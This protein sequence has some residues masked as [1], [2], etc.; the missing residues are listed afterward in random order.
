M[1]ASA[2]QDTY[3]KYAVAA[4]MLCLVVLV[5]L[6]QRQSF[7]WDTIQ[8]SSMQANFFYEHGF[9]QMLLPPEIDSGHPPGFGL[10]LAFCWTL[11]GKSLALSH[12]V[13]LP[14]LL[15][16]VY[17]L[18]RLGQYFFAGWWVLVAPLLALLDPVLLGQSVLVSPDIALVFFFL[19]TTVGLFEKRNV[20]LLL[21]GLGLVAISMRGMMVLAAL[22]VFQLAKSWLE[23]NKIPRLK[24]V[25]QLLLPFLPGAVLGFAFLSWHYMA[26]GWIGYHADSP[27]A[28]SFTKV[29]VSGFFKNIAVLGWRFLDFGRFVLFPIAFFL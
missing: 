6:S 1:S 9:R 13:M 21:G 23:V 29:D 24:N 26:A 22:Y 17:F 19:L 3:V 28:P 15:G 7:F 16:I 12:W 25:F 20:F 10:Y 5:A 27:W 2:Q 4:I 11:F 14:F 8:L 18:Y